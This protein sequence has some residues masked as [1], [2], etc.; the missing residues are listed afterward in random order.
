M[1]M[2]TVSL[3]TSY[4]GTHDLIQ[5]IKKVIGTPAAKPGPT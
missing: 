1:T 2:Q 5:E 4:G 3:N